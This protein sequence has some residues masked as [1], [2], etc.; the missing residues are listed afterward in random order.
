MNET[1][2]VVPGLLS[3]R[4]DSANFAHLAEQGIFRFMP[5]SLNLTAGDNGLFHGNN[6]RVHVSAFLAAVRLYA[7]AL[8]AFGDLVH[9]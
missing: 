5:F 3:G 6:E 2:L 1:L 8:Q 7:C 4:T 9:A